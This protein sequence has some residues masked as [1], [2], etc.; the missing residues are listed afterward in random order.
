MKGNLTAGGQGGCAEGFFLGSAGFCHQVK[1][2]R[3]DRKTTSR[4]I[5]PIKKVKEERRRL[6]RKTDQS[7]SCSVCICVLVF[8][9]TRV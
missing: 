9:G 6:R 3:A 5:V 1:Q 7:S 4:L 2:D 8:A